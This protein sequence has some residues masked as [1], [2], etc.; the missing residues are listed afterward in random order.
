MIRLEASCLN[1]VW[2]EMIV[3]TAAIE[4]EIEVSLLHFFL[5]NTDVV[6]G[7]GYRAVTEDLLEQQESPGIVIADQHLVVS[8]GLAESVGCYHD[9]KTERIGDLLQD[10]VDGHPAQRLVLILAVI[11]VAGEHVVAQVDAGGVFQVQR[12]SIDHGVVDCD[13]AVLLDFAGVAGFLLQDREAGLESKFIIDQMTEP[14]GK[15]ITDSKSEV[16]SNDE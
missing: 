12:H 9:V 14:Q 1:Q 2:E 11:G 15:Q 4:I 13:V 5:S 10:S 3:F 8:E 6:Q 7:L 16:D